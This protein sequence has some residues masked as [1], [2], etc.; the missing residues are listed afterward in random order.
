MKAQSPQGQPG[1]DPLRRLR[2]GIASRLAPK[3]GPAIS[4]IARSNLSIIVHHRIAAAEQSD[5]F[6]DPDNVSASPEAFSRQLLYLSLN[7]DVIS[8]DDLLSSAFND[9]KL[10]KRPVLITFDDGYRDNYVHALPELKSRNFPSI[11]FLAVGCVDDRYV[12]PW[13]NVAELFKAADP[14]TRELPLLGPVA[15]D[16]PGSRAEARRRFV[17]RLKALPNADVAEAVQDLAGSLGRSILARPPAGTHLGWS[18]VKE[19]AAAKVAI[20]GHTVTHPILAR[21][22]DAQASHE[23][24]TSKETIESRLGMPVVSFAYPN[25]GKND[26][27]KRHE[28]MLAESGIQLGF[29]TREGMTFASEVRNSPF[30]IRRTCIMSSDDLPR[31]AAKCA[32]LSRLVSF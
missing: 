25:G 18:E 27:N 24:R 22:D 11:L 1:R 10:P 32:G 15:I 7:F 30:S 12:F 26:F 14:G 29:S 3:L 2:R 13:D 19:M 20:G 9:R 6:G 23:I 31:F 16:S 21:A 28:A 17:G 5:F 4:R 8:I